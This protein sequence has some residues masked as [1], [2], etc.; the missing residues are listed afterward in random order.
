MIT[1]C[2]NP[3]SKRESLKEFNDRLQE[4]CLDDGAITIKSYAV[5]KYVCLA[6]STVD[7]LK[8]DDVALDDAGEVIPFPTIMPVVLGL[9]SEDGNWEEQIEL[10]VERE[11]KKASVENDQRDLIDVLF[12]Q[13]GFDPSKAWLIVFFNT[14][15]ID[16][17][18][19]G[20]EG[21]EEGDDGDDQGDNNP[22]QPINVGFVPT[23]SQ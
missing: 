12:L 6:V 4:F 23:L 5:G 10:L 20:E 21:G 22:P 8:V 16:P 11:K 3:S 14:G 2:F 13:N 1:F 17:P 9:S 18:E 19:F 15:E 7:D